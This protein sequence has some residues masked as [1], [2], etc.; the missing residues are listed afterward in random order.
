MLD[1]SIAYVTADSLAPSP[2]ARAFRVLER[3]PLDAKRI[4][5]ALAE[6]RI[7][8]IEIKKRGVDVDPAAFRK[9]L[10]PTGPNAATLVLTR[11]AGE[12]AALLVERCD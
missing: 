6:R 9:Q 10:R 4:A 3:W 11:I 7:G 1:A 5:K 2:F 8:T 12:R